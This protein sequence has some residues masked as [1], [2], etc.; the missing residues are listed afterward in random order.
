MEEIIRPTQPGIKT[1]LRIKPAP[2]TQTFLRMKLICLL[3]LPGLMACEG[4]FDQIKTIELDAG[5]PKLVLLSNFENIYSPKVRLSLSGDKPY[6]YWGSAVPLPPDTYPEAPPATVEVFEDGRSLGGMVRDSG[7]VFSFPAPYIP[8]P[9]KTYRLEVKAEGFE[10]V[11]AEGRIPAV[12]PVEAG[13]TGNYKFFKRWGSELKAAEIKLTLQDPPG[14]PNF[15]GLIIHSHLEDITGESAG[16]YSHYVYSDDLLFENVRSFSFDSESNS[17]RQIGYRKNLF[18]DK[19]FEGKKKEILI[20]VEV[21]HAENAGLPDIYFKLQNM[22]EDSYK[23]QL[24]Q[25]KARENN[26]NPFVQPILI[27]NNVKGGLGIFGTFSVTCDSLK[28]NY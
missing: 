5:P 14:Q 6:F 20:Y 3:M 19:T 12:V 10:T 17:R 28:I 18:T 8:L 7:S 1:G 2:G 26:E 11:Y 23:Y 27:Y 21:E 22:S 9:G 15:Y 4:T 16:N 24:T 25:E 13:F